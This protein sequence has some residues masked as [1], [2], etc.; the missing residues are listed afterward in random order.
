MDGNI[1]LDWGSDAAAVTATE[2]TVNAG[3][4]FEGYN[5]Y[6]LPG[7]GSPLTEGV[8]VAT[9]DKVNLIQNILDPSV[10]PLTGLVVNVVKQTGSDGGV[11]RYFNTD[12]DEVRGRP[13]SNGVEYYFAVTAYS[14][15]PDNE[16]SPF[17]TL[18]SGESRVTVVPH[19]PNP[20][21]TAGDLFGSAVTV[22]HSG[23]AT[24]S[25]SVDVVA[26]DALTGDSYRVSF[27]EQ[28]YYLDLEGNWHTTHPDSGSG[29]TTDLT[30]SSVSGVA[31]TSYDV[32][33]ID[34][35]FNVDVVSPDYNYAEGV[36]LV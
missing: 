28:A 17:K 1:S 8:K 34:V 2:A 25:V 23:T 11:Q 31:E 27:S 32:G 13:L 16:G 7:A 15:L 21:Y 3:F 36:L 22:T 12:Y 10:D 29:K 5:V 30:G 14:Y 18:E 4:E 35:V 19:D 9:Y 24:A 20:G 33:T 26:P 6:Q